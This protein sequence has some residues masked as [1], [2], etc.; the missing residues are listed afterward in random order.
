MKAVILCGGMG[1]RLKEE[2]E[3]R[4]KPLVLIGNKPILWHIMKI[5]SHYGVN[6]FVL[7]L[8]YKGEL[9]KEYF[10]NYNLFSNNATLNLKTHEKIIHSDEENGSNEDWRITFVDTGQETQTGGRVARIK[11]YLGNDEDFFLTYGDGVSNIDINELY[12]LHKSNKKAL[13]VTSI[14]PNLPFGLL[15]EENGEVNSFKEKPQIDNFVNG[16]FFVCNQKIFNYLSTEENCILETD[17]M[18]KLVNDRQVTMYKHHGFWQ[19][20]DTYKDVML[21][22]KLWKENPEWK[23]WKK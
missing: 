21:L 7:C 15:K 3:F 10:I 5:Y 11:K 20:M 4:P 17:V 2:T 18:N 14:R 12:K 16:G 13:T 8:G 1:T 6:D 22:N 19:N 9:I 23:I